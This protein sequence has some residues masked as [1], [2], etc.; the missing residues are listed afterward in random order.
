M[1]FLLEVNFRQGAPKE[2]TK[3]AATMMRERLEKPRAGVKVLSAVADLGGGKVF[4][5]A[6]YSEEATKDLRSFLEFRTLPA[7]ERID[8]TPVVEAKT[9]LD[10]YLSM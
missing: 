4:V 8:A 1:Q 2:E 10:T 6:D 7:V 9:A 5:L 3:A